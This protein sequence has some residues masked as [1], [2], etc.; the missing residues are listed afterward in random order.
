M[1]TSWSGEAPNYRFETEA[2]SGSYLTAGEYQGMRDLVH[3]PTGVQLAAGETLPGLVAPYRVFGN[4]RR[5]DDVRDRPNQAEV[6]PEGLRIR[7][8]SD[9]ANPFDLEQLYCWSGDV[10]DVHSTITAHE[11]LLRF[12]LCISSY[13][14]AGFRAFVSRQ[15]NEWGEQGGRIVPVDV[16]PMTDVYAMFPRDETAM[17]IMFD[18]RW[19]LPPYP[20]RWT[21]PAWFDLPL[22]YRR[23]AK[24][25]VMGLAMGDPRE[26]YAI[27]IS[28]N[29]PPEDPD[30]DRGYQA[31]YFYLF[32]R[33]IRQHEIAS[34]RVRWVIGKDLT[35]QEIHARWEAFLKD[36]E[37]RS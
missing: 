13:L 27:G 31:I 3:R 25:G 14:S 15:S 8:P 24:T 6:V 32:G 16:N 2:V 9:E 33:D 21:V 12:E 36:H 19:D 20:V 26:C 30:P 37:G 29:D 34:A 4:G 22:A 1:A 35:E 5:Y 7:Y 10:L 28:V 11:D 18:G 23:Q 17:G